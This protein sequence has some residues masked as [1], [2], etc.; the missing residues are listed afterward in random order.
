M[1]L[2]TFS[3]LL[4]LLL[5]IDEDKGSLDFGEIQGRRHQIIEGAGAHSLDG[6][7]SVAVGGDHGH[8]AIGIGGVQFGDELHSVGMKPDEGGVEGGLADD[9][10]RIVGCGDDGVDV[11]AI[12]KPTVQLALFVIE[13]EYFQEGLVRA[14]SVQ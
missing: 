1:I 2:D 13:M 3:L 14:G 12:G 11:A 7:A 4:L 5:A 10:E 6:A 8:E 9:G